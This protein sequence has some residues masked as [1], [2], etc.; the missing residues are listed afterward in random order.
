MLNFLWI[1]HYAQVHGSVLP[2]EYF[3]AGTISMIYA[4]VGILVWILVNNLRANEAELARNVL[5]LRRPRKSYFV[6]R[7]WRQSAGCRVRSRTRSEIR[8]R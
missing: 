7:N 6:K 4:F 2:N 5:I 3:E 8:S 1:A